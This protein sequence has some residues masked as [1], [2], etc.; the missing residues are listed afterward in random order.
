MGVIL[1]RVRTNFGN[2]GRTVTAQLTA[3]NQFQ[4]VTGT[5]YEP[6]PSVNY[7]TGPNKSAADSIYGAAVNILSQVPKNYLSFTSALP[8]AYG[9][10]TNIEFIQTLLSR[11]GQRIGDTIFA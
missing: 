7:R 4:A 9:K 3:K 8:S 10:G 6:G 1:N 5:N 11:G 2:H